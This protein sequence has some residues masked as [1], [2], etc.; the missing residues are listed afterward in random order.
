MHDAFPR[1]F[2]STPMGVGHV[3][4]WRPLVAVIAAMLVP[5]LVA[6]G[7]LSIAGIPGAMDGGDS[8]RSAILFTL[9]ALAMAPFLGWFLLP[10]LWP[11]ALAAAVRG[12][13]GL[14]S[15]LALSLSVGLIAVHFAL[16]GDLTTEDPAVLPFVMLALTLQG[17]TGWADFWVTMQFAQRRQDRHPLV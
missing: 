12:W 9:Y 10:L 1:R 7:L 8:L 5:A 11:L 16:H 2:R 6:W 17:T 15:V 13:A 3:G 14:L 4:L